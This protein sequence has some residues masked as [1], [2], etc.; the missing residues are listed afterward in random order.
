MA[1]CLLNTGYEFASFTYDGIGYAKPPEEEVAQDVKQWKE[2]LEPVLG[3]VSILFYANGSDLASY[4]GA[5]FQTLYEGGFR[6]FCALDSSVPSWVQIENTYVRQARRTINGTRITEEAGQVADLFD[7]TKIIP[8]PAGISSRP[9]PTK[10]VLLC[11]KLNQ[12]HPGLAPL[13]RFGLPFIRGGLLQS[14]PG[15]MT[16]WIKTDGGIVGILRYQLFWET[17]PFLTLLLL[18][19]AH[20]RQ[21]FGRAAMALWESELVRA[22]HRMVLV[23][24]RADESAQ[25]FTELWDTG[26]AAACFWMHQA[27]GSLLSSSCQNLCPISWYQAGPVASC[28]F[29]STNF[30]K[31]LKTGLLQNAFLQ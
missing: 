13:A 26:T 2:T 21:G 19:E 4:E 5:K 12:P 30:S 23:S 24:T 18:K 10:G 14:R 29:C 22:G 1:L 20:R 28:D 25:H 7:A 17:I 9:N 31:K 8:G 3:P 11:C 27:M 15:Q 16:R 6:Y